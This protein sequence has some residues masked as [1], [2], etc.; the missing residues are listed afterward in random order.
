MFL[1]SALRM[2]QLEMRTNLSKDHKYEAIDKE[3]STN[4]ITQKTVG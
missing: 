4:A 3:K 2:I 1:L